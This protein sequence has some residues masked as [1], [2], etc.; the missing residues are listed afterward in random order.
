MGNQFMAKVTARA[1]SASGSSQYQPA[2]ISIGDVVPGGKRA[3]R[4]AAVRIDAAIDPELYAST[5]LAKG[6]ALNSAGDFQQALPC[7]QSSLV[8]HQ[9]LYGADHAS[10]IDCQLHLA[11]AQ[12]RS[13]NLRA[14]RQTIESA[15]ERSRA[16]KGASSIQRG[17][18]LN[19]LAALELV[20]TDLIRAVPA[21]E[22][23]RRLLEAAL[24]PHRTLP[25]DT[26]ARAHSARGQYEQARAL[27]EEMLKIDSATFLQTSHPRYI[28][29]LHNFATVLQAQGDITAAAKAF[30]KV[31]QLIE[32]LYGD[33][34]PDL[35][36]VYANLGRLEQNRKRFDDAEE[37]F[38][39]ALEI[40]EELLGKKHAGYGYD[41]ANLGRLA[42]DRDDPKTA[43]RFLRDALATYA[44]AFEGKAHAYT[45]SA[46]TFLAY[47]QLQLKQADG[48]K[49]S[50]DQAAAMWDELAKQ[51]EDRLGD[52]GACDRAFA[53]ILGDCTEAARI[54][55]K[56]TAPLAVPCD[57][58]LLDDKLQKHDI[59]RR[60]LKLLAKRGLIKAG[61]AARG[62][63]TSAPGVAAAAP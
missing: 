40:S 13:G 26:L 6:V 38:E 10:I 50:I 32:D 42:L 15:V 52:A 12:R 4:S 19:E 9:Q 57:S 39:K 37:Y 16:H 47:A 44:Q 60:L 7:L 55:A 34:F 17:L 30:K 36:A 22:E 48:A 46:L 58:A 43:Q 51:C 25:M 14:A 62:N 21:A 33:T 31:A 41:L 49:Q 23:S 2:Y 27:Y 24:D 53:K 59:R 45:A 18:V 28:A 3:G 20:H 1:K 29:H 56:A 8:F 11:E 61:A 35:S 5:L 54:S 63:P